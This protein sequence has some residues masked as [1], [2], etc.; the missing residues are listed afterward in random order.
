MSTAVSASRRL[1]RTGQGVAMAAVLEVDAY[2]KKSSGVIVKPTDRPFLLIL[3]HG[4]IYSI[5]AVTYQVEVLSSAFQGELWVSGSFEADIRVGQFRVVVVKDSGS[6]RFRF[7]R[8]YYRTILQRVRVLDASVSARKVVLSY[9]PFHNGLLG[10]L[11]KLAV[12]WPLIV[13]I[14]GVFG[15]PDNYRDTP[16]LVARKI[17]PM[18]LRAA[19]RY[20]IRNADGI[21]LL[22]HKQLG[23]FARAPKSAVIRQYFD[24]VRLELFEPRPEEKI[25]LLLGYPFHLKGV[26]ILLSAFEKVHSE[27]PEWRLVLIGHELANHIDV[28]PNYLTV[29][30]GVPQREAASWISRC[31]V[32][33]L[34]SR[35]EAMG[36][37]LIEAAAAAKPR[38][39]ADVG[40]T[41]TVVSHDV[42][43]LLFKAKDVPALAGALRRLMKD[44]ELRS[45][46]GHAAR[47]RAFSQF[48]ADQ[49]LRCV[50]DLVHAVI[51]RTDR[52]GDE[53]AAPAPAVRET[54]WSGCVERGA[55]IVPISIG[56]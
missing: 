30:R 25:V 54:N 33:V 44:P 49:Y 16:G 27:F 56:K 8:E 10:R 1:S 15:N 7:T 12:G 55:A 36:R 17:K 41:H 11:I 34:P 45:R 28:T 42:D 50:A 3:K 24:A 51:Q 43:G 46:L 22:F 4:P 53:I 29:I 21:R 19:G 47:N 26:D 14:N 52:V 20:V 13:E 18:V 23:G 48:G 40:G 32:L 31:A 38:I 9:D 37:V 6:H 5:E 35:S 2:E 39:A